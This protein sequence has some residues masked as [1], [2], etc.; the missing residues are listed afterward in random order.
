MRLPLFSPGIEERNDFPI[1]RVK[2]FRLIVFMPV[3]A[4]ARQRQI[5]QVACAAAT[6][7]QDVLHGK[8]LRCVFAQA[9]A[10][11]ATAFCPFDDG[12]LPVNRNV[13][14]RHGLEAESQVGS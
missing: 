10:V 6:H 4:R 13:Y 12:L 7:R 1:C 3:A 8:R 5:I 11:F 2:R 14:S 9:Q